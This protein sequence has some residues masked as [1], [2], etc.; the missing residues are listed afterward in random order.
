MNLGNLK[1]VWWLEEIDLSKLHDFPTDY[2]N[3]K[4]RVEYY[5][6]D[7][8]S[9]YQPLFY[10]DSGDD[11]RMLNLIELVRTGTPIIPPICMQEWRQNSC[12]VWEKHRNR[13]ASGL[14]VFDGAHRI[15]LCRA[16]NL[17]IIPALVFDEFFTIEKFMLQHKLNAL[18]YGCSIG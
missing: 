14:A 7:Q 5:Q 10:G 12:G 15:I 13:T 9:E 4:T 8:I 18:K 3:V 16:M 1:I 6:L 17:D 11:K 2:I